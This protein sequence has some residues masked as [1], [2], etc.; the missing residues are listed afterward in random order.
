MQVNP[1]QKKNDAGRFYILDASRFLAAVAV[2]LFHY[3]FL[4]WSGGHVDSV[5]FES[6]GEVFKY[7]YLGVQFF[8]LISGFVIFMSIQRGGGSGLHCVQS[9]SSLPRILVWGA[10]HISIR[11]IAR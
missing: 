8:F 2:V 3:L 1:E 4:G 5:K 9:I 6:A 11:H 7:G 10:T